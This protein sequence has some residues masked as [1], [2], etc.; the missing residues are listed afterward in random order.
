MRSVPYQEKVCDKFF[1]EVL[2]LFDAS[3]DRHFRLEHAGLHNY[4]IIKK[5]DTLDG[6]LVFEFK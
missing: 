1:P 3:E 5:Y 2:F 6:V 4:L